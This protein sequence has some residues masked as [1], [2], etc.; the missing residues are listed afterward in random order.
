[1]FHVI[2]WNLTSIIRHSLR[3]L[4]VISVGCNCWYLQIFGTKPTPISVPIVAHK[5]HDGI[6]LHDWEDWGA[7]MTFSDSFLSSSLRTGT[8]CYWPL[9]LQQCGCLLQ[10]H[11]WWWIANGDSSVRCMEIIGSDKKYMEVYQ[12]SYINSSASMDDPQPS[13]HPS[14]IDRQPLPSDRFVALCPSDL[15]SV[16]RQMNAWLQPIF[17]R[18]PLEIDNCHIR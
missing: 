13:I 17:N 3:I 1:M 12:L 8:C 15:Q 4:K 9:R 18:E 16:D 2:S 5:L 10:N 11:P 14:I 7:R 6:S